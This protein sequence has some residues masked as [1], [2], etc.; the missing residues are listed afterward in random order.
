[1]PDPPKCC[2]TYILCL[3]VAGGA[4][5]SRSMAWHRWAVHTVVAE[6]VR[7][8]VALWLGRAGVQL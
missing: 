8:D 3:G 4:R 6:N 5:L 7:L 1:M 2:G